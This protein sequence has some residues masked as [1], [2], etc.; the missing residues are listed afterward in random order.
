LCCKKL[1]KLN[2]EAK[3][4]HFADFDIKYQQLEE[5]HKNFKEAVVTLKD[6][7]KQEDDAADYKDGFNDD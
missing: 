4:E 7:L 6:Q 3:V 2:K 5:L 1:K